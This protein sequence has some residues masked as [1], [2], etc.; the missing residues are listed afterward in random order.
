MGSAAGWLSGYLKKRYLLH[1]API[2]LGAGTALFEGVRT[3]LH[4]PPSRSDQQATGHAPHLRSRAHGRRSV[5]SPAPSRTSERFR[6][7]ARSGRGP[8]AGVEGPQPPASRERHLGDPVDHMVRLA[9]FPV[10]AS[11]RGH[12]SYH[13]RIPRRRRLRCSHPFARTGLNSSA[14]VT[15]RWVISP[16][17][18]GRL[19]GTP[20]PSWPRRAGGPK[21]GGSS[22]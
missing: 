2:V 16:G 14:R 1:L 12:R 17:A 18:R 15:N 9:D 20:R 7:G 5:E 3:D 21:P 11:R 4:P 8:S 19:L 10:L 6:P 13:A 22:P